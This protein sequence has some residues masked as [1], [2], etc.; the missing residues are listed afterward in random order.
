[1]VPRRGLGCN[2]GAV[3]LN[4][5]VNQYKSPISD[6][7]T[8]GQTGKEFDLNAYKE[9]MKNQNKPNNPAPLPKL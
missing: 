6:Q 2:F 9:K 8:I 5:S 7:I 3:T 4:V 1:M